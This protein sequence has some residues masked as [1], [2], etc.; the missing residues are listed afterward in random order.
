MGKEYPEMKK[1]IAKRD[2]RS[3]EKNLLTKQFGKM[4]LELAVNYK[5]RFF[6]S[7]DYLPQFSQILWNTYSFKYN[8]RQIT[9]PSWQY[10]IK[11]LTLNNVMS[12]TSIL[13]C[14]YVC[15]L[16]HEKETNP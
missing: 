4:G 3:T 7:A 1:A 5:K 11:G 13:M 12:N 9:C 6:L 15:T 10:I 8:Y 14:I 2:S 16:T